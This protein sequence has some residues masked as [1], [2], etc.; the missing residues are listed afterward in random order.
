MIETEGSN[1]AE[2]LAHPEVDSSKTVSNNMW[3][4]Y[5]ILGIE[6]ARAFLIEEFSLVISSDSTYINK[7]HIKLLVDMMT[8]TGIISSISRYGM[9]MGDQTG[10]MGRASFEESLDNFLKA[11]SYGERET[12]KGVSASIMCGKVSNIGTGLC[13]LGIDMSKLPIEEEDDDDEEEYIEI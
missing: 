9:R 8:Y 4:I 5:D 3:E 2:L 6:A 11:G 10:A 1:L 13:Q 12:T 7:R